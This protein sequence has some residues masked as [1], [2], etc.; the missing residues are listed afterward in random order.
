MKAS[1]GKGV[2]MLLENCPYPQ[3]GRVRREAK[4]LLFA[5]FEVTVIC[6][7]GSGQPRRDIVDGVRVYRHR[8]PTSSNGFLGYLWEYGYAMTA[9]FFLS[10]FVWMRHGFDVVHAHNPPDT[11]VFIAV[12]YKV[13]GKRFIFDHHDLSPE[14][15]E[16]RFRGGNRLVF[17]ALMW[18][19]RLSCRLADHVIATNASYREVVMQR[20]K[21]STDRVT[22]V[23]NGPELER[24]RVGTPDAV[25]RRKAGTII[26]Y[27]GVMGYQDG[28]DYLL[29]ALR[30]L[31]DDVGR[32]DFFCVLVGSGDARES[33]MALTA[34]LQLDKHVWFTGYVP[35]EDLMRYLSTAD[36]FVDPDPSNAFNDRST[37]IKIMEYMALGKPIVAF[38]LPEHRVTA[39]GAA[40]YAC[41]NDEAD[42][43]RT[44]GRLMDDPL[45]R[46]EMGRIGR[47]RVETQLA[48]PLQEPHLLAAY[49]KIGMAVRDEQPAAPVSCRAH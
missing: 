41:A 25:L 14:M 3:D 39:E 15:Y 29:R 35:D 5:G 46:E 30:H 1:A 2:L 8:G 18:L 4:T 20:G 9:T 27:V 38:D 44:I 7:S 49:E 32:T 45:K 22:I 48:W 19:E 11:F 10:L 23:R 12:F 24:V 43:A 33:L 28:V 40:L 26:G 31:I 36:L 17:R 47:R 16:A 34:E 21:V 37:M 6:P 13:F 42:F